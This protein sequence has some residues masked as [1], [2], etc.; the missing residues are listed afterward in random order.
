MT[1]LIWIRFVVG[2]CMRDG[3]ASFEAI[4]VEVCI[5]TE[6]LRTRTMCVCGMVER[7]K[8]SNHPQTA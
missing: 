1:M 6:K 2:L 7:E 4:V 3:L 5:P 8:I